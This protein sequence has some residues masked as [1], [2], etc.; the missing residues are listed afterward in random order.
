MLELYLPEMYREVRRFARH[1]PNFGYVRQI[2]KWHT[3]QGYPGACYVW[4]EENRVAAFQA[5][6]YLN[7]DDAW[8]WGMRVDPDFQNRGV[9]TRFTR[10]LFPVIRRAGRTWAGLNTL[11]NRKPKST[12]RV[13]EKLG[14]KLE[15]VDATDAFWNLPARL[16]APRPSRFPGIYKHFRS[17]GRNTV[18]HQD[19]GWLWSR[20]LPARQRRVNRFG[21]VLHGTPLH[22][23]RQARS[24]YSTWDASVTTVN[25]FDLPEDL[26][27]MA[28]SLLGYAGG[29]KRSVVVAYP[30]SWRRQFREAFKAVVPG[31]KRGKNCWFSCW[32][33]Y[34]KHFGTRGQTQSRPAETA[35]A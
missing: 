29:H 22:I 34:A 13:A 9:A 26:E 28:R 1:Q 25:I 4:K 14:M 23:Y 16:R 18:F 15:D 17:L 19:P 27:R 3:E 31:L 6:A 33:I 24:R 32:R 5:V 8:L 7:P 10:A 30:E 2:I 12:F 35:G 11:D 20:L 21:R